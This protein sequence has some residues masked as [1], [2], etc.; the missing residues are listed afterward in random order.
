MNKEKEKNPGRRRQPGR[1]VSE[2][3]RFSAVFFSF[4][5]PLMWAIFIVFIEFVTIL[6]LFYILVFWP[7]CTCDLSSPIR[8]RTR[9][10]CI[11]RWSLNHWTTREV[12]LLFS[13]T[14]ITWV[15]YCCSLLGKWRGK[16]TSNVKVHLREHVSTFELWYE[17]LL[18]IS[19]KWS[20]DS[21]TFP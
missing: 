1:S 15:G 11:G 5:F 2:G 19:Q 21:L 6:P 3:I 18:I 17:Y 4:F 7:Q 16:K 8:D 20:R 13:W 9:T 10:P 12:P 14:K